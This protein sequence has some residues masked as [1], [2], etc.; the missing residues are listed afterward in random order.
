MTSP[1]KSTSPSATKPD[2]R[3]GDDAAAGTATGTPAGRCRWPARCRSPRRSAPGRGAAHPMTGTDAEAFLHGTLLPDA[4]QRIVGAR[5][6]R[7]RGRRTTPAVASAPMGID[8]I[9]LDARPAPHRRR[10]GRQRAVGAATR[11]QAH[12]RPRRRRGGAARRHLRLPRPRRRVVHRL[13]VLHRE[14]APAPRRGPVPHELQRVVAAASA[15]RA[16]RPGRADA[17]RRSPRLAGA[18]AG[19]A[20]HGRGPR[21]HPAQ[22]AG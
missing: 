3:D 20:P 5:S 19:A 10:D 21:A 18:Q 6:R 11:A 1:A 12:R 22:H 13:R 16:A 4:R 15:R 17:L 14:L 7:D 2:D 8:G 9:D